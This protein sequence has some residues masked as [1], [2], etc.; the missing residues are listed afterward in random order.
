MKFIIT[1]SKLEN[2][3]FSYIDSLLDKIDFYGEIYYMYKGTKNGLIKYSKGSDNNYVSSYIIQDVSNM[4]SIGYVEAY[5]YI[6]NWAKSRVDK[7][8]KGLRTTPYYIYV[9]DYLFP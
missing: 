6:L 1:E 7:D 2:A 5:S 4:F 8:V 3:I 9:S